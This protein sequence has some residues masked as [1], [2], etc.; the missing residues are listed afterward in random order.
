[1]LDFLATSVKKDLAR[2]SRDKTA[3]LIWLGIPFL[4]G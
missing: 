3:L 4:I 1:M 2:W